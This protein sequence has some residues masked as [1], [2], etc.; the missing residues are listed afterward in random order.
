MCLQC[1]FI[2]DELVPQLLQTLGSEVVSN[3]L[4]NSMPLLI[5][6]DR[7]KFEDITNLITLSSG[8]KTWCYI[9][10]FIQ[11]PQVFC[12]MMGFCNGT[13]INKAL[14]TRIQY[15]TELKKLNKVHVQSKTR[16]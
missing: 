12:N 6:R 14:V 13:I 4:E 1:D 8:N 2:V 15:R 3:V 11:D 7:V 9:Y 5:L 16:S 10:S